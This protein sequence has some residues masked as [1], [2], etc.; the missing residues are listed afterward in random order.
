MLRRIPAVAVVTVMLASAIVPASVAAQPAPP[1]LPSNV[2]VVA[3]GLLN[4]RGFTWGPEGDLYVAEAGSPPAGYKPPQGPPAPGGPPVTN[5]N[6]RISRIDA[7]GA[8]TTIAD[9]LP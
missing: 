4:P 6:G 8:R 5:N 7:S 3:G 9:G 1:P 2:Q